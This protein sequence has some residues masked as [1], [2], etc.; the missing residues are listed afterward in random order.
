MRICKF[1]KAQIE[2][3]KRNTLVFFSEL[4]QFNPKYPLTTDNILIE[5][6]LNR[7]LPE[8]GI[9]EPSL[10]KSRYTRNRDND[11]DR[12]IAT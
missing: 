11:P 12:M 2:S 5:V 6:I 10:V 9:K 3:I 4:R 7:R 1:I 8:T